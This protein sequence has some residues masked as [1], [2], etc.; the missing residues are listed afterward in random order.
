MSCVPWMTNDLGMADEG[1]RL[2]EGE[3]RASVCAE[4]G[5]STG[6]VEPESQTFR[7]VPISLCSGQEWRERSGTD[8]KGQV[9]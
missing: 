7:I 6:E 4:E 5:G 2:E 8:R 1:L 9:H 3:R